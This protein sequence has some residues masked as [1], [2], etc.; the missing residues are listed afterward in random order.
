MVLLTAIVFLVTLPIGAT[1]MKAALVSG[2]ESTSSSVSDEELASLLLDELLSSL[3][4][5]VSMPKAN[6]TASSAINLFRIIR[7]IVKFDFEPSH[8]ATLSVPGERLESR[9]NKERS[10]S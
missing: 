5:A 9:V 4:H 1:I 8:H 7:P 3:P 10:K 2:P 6:S